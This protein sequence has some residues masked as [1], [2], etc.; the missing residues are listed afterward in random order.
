MTQ[1]KRQINEGINNLVSEENFVHE[2]MFVGN[3][4]IQELEEE[5][6][7]LEAYNEKLEEELDQNQM[8]FNEKAK[9]W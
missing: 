9:D 5:K 7:M 6:K 1:H 8:E 3:K 4:E 2:M